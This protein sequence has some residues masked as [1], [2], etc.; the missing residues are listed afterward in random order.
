MSGR[1]QLILLFFSQF[2][3]MILNGVFKLPHLEFFQFLPLSFQIFRKT[4]VKLVDN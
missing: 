2:Y 1:I 4:T 3:T